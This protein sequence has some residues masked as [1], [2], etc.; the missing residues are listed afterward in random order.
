MRV[1]EEKMKIERI[2]Q[3]LEQEQIDAFM[4]QSAINRRYISGFTGTFGTVFITKKKA[5][6]ITDF[7]YV[8]QANEQAKGFEVIENRNML[9][10]VYEQ[11]QAEEIKTLAYEEEHTTVSMYNQLQTYSAIELVGVAGVIEQ[12]R[13]IK[14]PDELA[15]IKTAASISDKAFERILQDIKAGVTELEICNKLEMYMREEGATSSSFDMIIA[16]GHRS[17]LPHGV[18]S[19]KKIEENDF[20]TLD[21]GALYEGYCS[22]MTRTVVVGSPSTQLEKVYHIVND[23][24]TLGIAEVK[25]GASCSAVDTTVRNF[26]TEH[27]YG[28]QFGHGLGHSFGLEIHESPYFAKTSEEVLSPQMVMTIE[29]G[30]YIPDVGGVR[31]E[32]DVIVTEDG[33][34]VITHSPKEL[35]RL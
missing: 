4:I 19:T 26:I 15:K 29:P 7:R 13:M 2:Q 33:C 32:D 8:A 22:D 28:E 5:Y 18:A 20:V 31:I 34:D 27:G 14:T 23:A 11:C 35:I 30:I 17:A 3:Y 16:S 1:S 9:E 25:A 24:L 6:F 21:F 12:M 10:A